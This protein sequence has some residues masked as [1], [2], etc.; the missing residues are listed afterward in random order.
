MVRYEYKLLLLGTIPRDWTLGHIAI[1]YTK[2][3]KRE[4][5]ACLI[6]IQEKGVSFL[7]QVL[8]KIKLLLSKK[9]LNH[10]FLISNEARN[11][12]FDKGLGITY[13]ESGRLK[14]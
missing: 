2:K 9:V 4:V 5:W 13:K 1:V 6:R 14:I 3:G 12:G 11:Q 8:E 7:V 10:L